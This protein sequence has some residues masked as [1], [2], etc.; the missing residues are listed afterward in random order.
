LAEFLPFFSSLFEHQLISQASIQLLNTILPFAVGK[1]AKSIL[2]DKVKVGSNAGMKE[3]NVLLSIIL[4]QVSKM[5]AHNSWP[6]NALSFV[7]VLSSVIKGP[8]SYCGESEGT[9]ME[10]EVRKEIM[11]KISRNLDDLKI[12]LGELAD[13]KSRHSIRIAFQEYSKVSF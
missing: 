11:H 5:E 12:V 13:L 8:I 4:R 10:S 7:K 2:N 9:E 6:L 1:V 3:L